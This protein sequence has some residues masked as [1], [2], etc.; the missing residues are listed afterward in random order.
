MF[1]DA[2]AAKLETY[3]NE[4]LAMAWAQQ[5]VDV[6]SFVGALSTARHSAHSHRGRNVVH[7][8]RLAD[9][10][11]WGD[12]VLFQCQNRV[13]RLQRTVTGAEWDHVAIV[14]QSHVRARVW[15]SRCGLGDPLTRS[16]VCSLEAA[17]T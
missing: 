1:L 14:V 16:C 11:E 6:L 8:S 13:S 2:R 3:L 9:S 4:L 7:I 5:H 17:R 12:I 10:V 15:T